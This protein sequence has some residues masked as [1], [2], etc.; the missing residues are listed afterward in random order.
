MDDAI[1]AENVSTF[2]YLFQYFY[3]L[4]QMHGRMS[5]CASRTNC[6]IFREKTAGSQVYSHNESIL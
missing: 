6:L 4:L 5:Q 3:R 1:G 2:V